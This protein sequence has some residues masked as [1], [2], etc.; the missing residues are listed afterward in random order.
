MFF[1][2]V[3]SENTHNYYFMRAKLILIY[4]FEKIQPFILY[5]TY[6]KL[7]IHLPKQKFLTHISFYLK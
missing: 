5:L 7:F 3:L 2:G 1:V 4:T 6:E